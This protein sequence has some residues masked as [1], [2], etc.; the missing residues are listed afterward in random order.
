MRGNESGPLVIFTYE[1]S[2]RLG[3]SARG[4][5][6]MG[7]GMAMRKNLIIFTDSGDTIIDEST[8]VFDERGIV[9]EAAF[10]P[11]AGEVLRELKEEG[12]PE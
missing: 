12:S 11:G 10:I 2:R 6:Q 8:Q 3:L 9:T 7:V 1:R 4:N 5:G